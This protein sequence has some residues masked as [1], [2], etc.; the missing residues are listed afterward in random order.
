MAVIETV[1]SCA[2]QSL[3]VVTPTCVSGCDVGTSNKELKRTAQGPAPPV[4]PS[5]AA[6]LPTPG[7]QETCCALPALSLQSCCPRVG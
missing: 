4:R 3:I 7:V 5:G 2:G 1:P 6:V